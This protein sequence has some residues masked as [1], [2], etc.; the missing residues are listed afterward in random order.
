MRE[1]SSI[2][3]GIGL[4][5]FGF[6]VLNNYTGATSILTG[7]SSSGVNLITALQGRGNAA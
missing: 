1:I 3:G 6:L 4:L 7:V 2:M 5:I